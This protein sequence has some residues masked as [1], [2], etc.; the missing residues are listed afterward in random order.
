MVDQISFLKYFFSLIPRKEEVSKAQS[1]R[2]H[3]DIRP[4][5]SSLVTLVSDIVD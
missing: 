2:Y 1:M 3:N 4:L 5:K